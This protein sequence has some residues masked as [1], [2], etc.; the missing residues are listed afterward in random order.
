MSQ[1]RTK[2]QIS[3]SRSFPLQRIHSTFVSHLSQATSNTFALQ[4]LDFLLHSKL[5]E[6]EEHVSTAC[7]HPHE[8]LGEEMGCALSYLTT[9][10]TASEKG[11]WNLGNEDR[12]VK[13]VGTARA[14][15]SGRRSFFFRVHLAH[16][17]TVSVPHF[18]IYINNLSLFLRSCEEVSGIDWP[19]LKS[20]SVS[21]LGQSIPDASSQDHRKRAK[22]LLRPH[23]WLS[24]NLSHAQA[25]T[26]DEIFL[27]S[28]Q[29]EDFAC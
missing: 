19:K 21:T 17:Y 7:T 14:Q 5:R 23:Y 1:V 2:S 20:L 10:P 26:S 9:A 13:F 27:K 29:H 24:D 4:T 11:T 16:S 15:W 25:S 28:K 12:G 22:S 6:G 18:L 3:T 8:K